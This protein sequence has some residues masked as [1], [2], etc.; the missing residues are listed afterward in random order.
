MCTQSHG[1]HL[2]QSKESSSEMYMT[3]ALNLQRNLFC[4]TKPLLRGCRT[5]HHSP[6]SY[7]LPQEVWSAL[8]ASALSVRLHLNARH[9]LLIPHSQSVWG[10]QA[11][12]L[13]S[14]DTAY[15]IPT[16]NS[17]MR[18]NKAFTKFHINHKWVQRPRVLYHYCSSRQ[19]LPARWCWSISVPLWA[20]LGCSE[21]TSGRCCRLQSK[22]MHSCCISMA[23]LLCHLPSFLCPSGSSSSPLLSINY[24]N[25]QQF[26][27]MPFWCSTALCSDCASRRDLHKRQSRKH[28]GKSFAQLPR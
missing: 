17:V 24:A 16:V 7:Y 13:D 9:A 3:L 20:P 8:A 4:S 12:F 15:T 5:C 27:R 28:F 10:R 14:L 1:P 6:S 11:L 23:W 19:S 2:S 26:S 21:W 22:L 25:N 18:Q